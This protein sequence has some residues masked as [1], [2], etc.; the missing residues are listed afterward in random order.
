M[1]EEDVLLRLHRAYSKDEFVALLKKE[2]AD[3]NFKNGE[4]ISEVAELKHILNK[5]THAQDGLKNKKVWSKDE[6]IQQYHERYKKQQ[7]KNKRLEKSLIE[8]R[9]KYFSL[10]AS[11]KKDA[12]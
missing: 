7:E 8:W 12:Q 6:V 10:A 4:L 9:N 11:I 2:I 5:V 3:L 1:S